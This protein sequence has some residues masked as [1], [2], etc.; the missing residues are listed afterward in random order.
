[1]TGD[2]RGA[3]WAD[4]YRLDYPPT[5]RGQVRL[6]AGRHTL[7]RFRPDGSVLSTS[8][9]D[10]SSTSSARATARVRVRGRVGIFF[11][12]GNGAAKG[13]MVR[14]RYGVAYFPGAAVEARYEP[15][16]TLTFAHRR[17]YRIVRFTSRWTPTTREVSFTR[18]STAP[19]TRRAV[20]NGREFF[21]IAAGRHEGAWVETSTVRIT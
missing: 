17:V 11:V 21:R 19:T 18:A 8:V 1:M 12:L 6:V 14:E 13:W 20:V 5:G 9:L 16:R 10:L 7:Y 2:P 3:R 4:T 15:R